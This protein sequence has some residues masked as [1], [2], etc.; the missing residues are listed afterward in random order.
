MSKR[1]KIVLLATATCIFLVGVRW[2]NSRSRPVHTLGMASGRLA[3]CPDLANCVSTE[4]ANSEYRLDPI[5]F[6]LSAE[7]AQRQL[8]AVI[9]SLPRS[10]IVTS[11]TGYIHAE[12]R[13]L[14]LGFV[15][16][17]E[18]AIDENKKIIDFRSASRIG[19]SD[20]GV[21]RKRMAQIRR[22]FNNR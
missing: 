21:N 1:T 2:V 6:T 16:D 3:E 7:E 10:R 13:S 8:Q 18:L 11:K 14:I 4:A 19:H 12:F 9:R 17:V 22:Q 5:P 15:D 20:L